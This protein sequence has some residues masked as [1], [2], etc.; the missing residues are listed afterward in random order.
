MII[1]IITVILIVLL[2][3]MCCLY[4]YERY[5]RSSLIQE[6]D[7]ECREQKLKLTDDLLQ[8]KNKLTQIMDIMTQGTIK[9]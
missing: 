1:H 2:I 9:K 7:N 8:A 5:N 4:G 6:K 3:I